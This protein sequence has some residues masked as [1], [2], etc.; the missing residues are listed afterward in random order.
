[1]MTAMILQYGGYIGAIVGVVAA[2]FAVY[3]G[4]K[5]KGGAKAQVDAMQEQSAFK[6][7]LAAETI[8]QERAAN[9]TAMTTVQGASDAQ[10]EVLRNSDSANSDELRRDWTRD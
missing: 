6:D 8:I 4:G 9:E 2:F 5:A 1:M 7:H 10:T 3:F